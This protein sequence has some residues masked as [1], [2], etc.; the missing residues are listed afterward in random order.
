MRMLATATHD[1]K[2]G[3]DVRARINVLSEIPEM[4]QKALVK[5]SRL[6]KGK[7]VMVDGQPVPDRNEEYLLYQTLIGAWPAER[8]SMK[9]LP[10]AVK[11]ESGSIWS[12]R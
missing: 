8:R 11:E 12:R 10:F 1:S 9:V 2:R 6:N 4:W 3:E 7:R 5:W